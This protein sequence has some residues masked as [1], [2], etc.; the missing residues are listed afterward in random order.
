MSSNA[1]RYGH[2]IDGGMDFHLREQSHTD[3]RVS[4]WATEAELQA[5]ADMLRVDIHVSLDRQF[6]NWNRFVYEEGMNGASRNVS[7]FLLL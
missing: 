6:V 3:G 2:L 5:T 7:I 4:S 1:E